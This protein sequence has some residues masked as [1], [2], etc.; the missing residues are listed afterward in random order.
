[1]TLLSKPGVTYTIHTDVYEGPLDLLLDLI[2]KAELDITRLSLAKVTD[3]YLSYLASMGQKSA[4]EVSGFLVIA[5]KLIQIK[6]EAILPRPPERLEGEEDPAESLAR[7]LRIYKAIKQTTLWLRHLEQKGQHTYIR[8]AP[9]PKIDETI[10]LSGVEISDLI[11]L[12]KALYHFQEDA[13]PITTVVTIPRVTIKNKIK[14]L[15]DQLRL[16]HNLSYRQMLPKEYDRVEA[17]VLF[18]AVLELIKQHYVDAMQEGLFS[19]IQI[20]ATDKTHS[21][22]EITLALEA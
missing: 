12:L 4:V 19:D 8:L 14:D 2:T 5:A 21:D 20:S 9:P 17:I 10:D 13:S 18:L 11:S 22:N 3:Q 1:M 16:Q 7:Q 15:I 6:S